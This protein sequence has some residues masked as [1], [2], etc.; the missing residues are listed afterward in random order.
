[1]EMSLCNKKSYSQLPDLY[2]PVQAANVRTAPAINNT[3]FMSFLL[4]RIR[5]GNY[6]L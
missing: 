6:S 2:E 4:C 3:F 1:M 5:H